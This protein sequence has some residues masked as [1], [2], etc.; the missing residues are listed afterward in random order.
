MYII[1][2]VPVESTK[3]LIFSNLLKQGYLCTRS[4]VYMF[5]TKG[6][7]QASL[8]SFVYFC[9]LPF[10]EPRGVCFANKQKPQED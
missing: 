1:N 4:F 9:L 5:N 8:F 7:L 6:I 2:C 10:A 3:F